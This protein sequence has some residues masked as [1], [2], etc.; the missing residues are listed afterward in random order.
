MTFM[1]YLEQIN[2]FCSDGRKNAF[3]DS[4]ERVLNCLIFRCALRRL[5]ATDY[6]DAEM[7]AASLKYSGDIANYE[8]KQSKNT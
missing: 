8:K 1:T 4:L 5:K 3:S 7:S 6:D 2:C